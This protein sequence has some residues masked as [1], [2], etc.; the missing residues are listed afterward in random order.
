MF[1][2]ITIHVSCVY[3]SILNNIS[4]SFL[5]IVLF[6][7]LH[8]ICS[9]YFSLVRDIQINTS[10]KLVLEIQEQT[11]YSSDTEKNATELKAHRQIQTH[12]T[13]LIFTAPEVFSRQ[14][15]TQIFV[16]LK[17]KEWKSL[18]SHTGNL[19]LRMRGW[20]MVFYQLHYCLTERQNELCAI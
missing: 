3:C 13:E 1:Q 14:W 20:K 7:I 4:T 19:H 16:T 15:N 18:Q 2:Y 11:F 12:Y 9:V 8:Y 10:K 17:K 6:N 5:W